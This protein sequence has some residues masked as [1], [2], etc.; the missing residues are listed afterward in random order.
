[1]A[2][3]ILAE[4]IHRMKANPDKFHG[5]NGRIAD[6]SAMVPYRLQRLKILADRVELN[7]CL[8]VRKVEL[9][10]MEPRSRYG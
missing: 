7:T 1:M 3:L 4:R 2:L 10:N 9:Q 6:V 8:P 5:L